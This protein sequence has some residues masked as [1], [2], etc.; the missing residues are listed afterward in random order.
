MAAAAGLG[1]DDEGVFGGGNT[2]AGRSTSVGSKACSFA[3]TAVG[4][5]SREMAEEG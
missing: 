1:G 3:A 5:K 4:G 2:V